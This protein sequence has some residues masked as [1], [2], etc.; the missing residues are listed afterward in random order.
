[1]VT[2]SAHAAALMRLGRRP[3]AKARRGAGD[4]I[5]YRYDLGLQLNLRWEK[6]LFRLSDSGSNGTKVI[7]SEQM[8][9]QEQRTY[10]RFL[11]PQSKNKSEAEAESRLAGI[12]V[13]AD[14]SALADSIHCRY[15]FEV[16]I[17]SIQQGLQVVQYQSSGSIMVGL[18]LI[19]AGLSAKW[20][21]LRL[22]GL[23]SKETAWT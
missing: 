13:H 23:P 11:D 6:K 4:R 7:V 2:L 16:Q 20:N 15:V 17:R 19:A 14:T 9:V 10:T 8:G 1:M 22:R 5:L 18:P 21:V 12:L 3:R